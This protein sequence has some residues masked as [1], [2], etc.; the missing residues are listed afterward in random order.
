MGKRDFTMEMNIGLAYMMD[1]ELE[2]LLSKR[3][4]MK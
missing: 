4:S 3:V 2:V 1:R